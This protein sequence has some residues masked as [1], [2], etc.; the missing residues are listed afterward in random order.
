MAAALMFW[1]GLVG[2]LPAQIAQGLVGFLAIVTFTRMLSPE[3]YGAYALGF[4]AMSLAHTLAFTWLEAA[5]ARFYPAE[6]QEGGRL[7]D[8]FATIYRTFIVAAVLFPVV[9][10]LALWLWPVQAEVKLAVGA[11][12]AAVMVRSLAKLAQERRRAAG[13]VRSASLLDIAQTT[14]GFAAGAALIVVGFGGAAPMAGMGV[15]AAVSLAFVLPAELRF[16]KGGNFEPQRLRRYAA[17]GLP[18]AASLVLALA[19]ATT[20]RFLLAAYLNEQ[21]VG[22]Y[23]AGYSLSN[24]TLDVLFIW[25][26][27]A[28]G[29]AMVMALERGGEPALKASAR[30]QA[31]MMAALAFPAAVGLALVARPL[32]EVMIGP[33]LRDG[34]A[35]VT[36]WVAMSALFSGLTTYYFHQAFTLARRTPRLLAAMAIPALANI[37]LNVLLIPRFGLDGAM[38][39]TAASYGVGLISSWGLGRSVM[40]L[41]VPIEAVT[42]AAAATALMAFVVMQLPAIG[43]VA[44]LAL[45]SMAGAGVYGVCAILLDVGGLRTRASRLIAARRAGAAA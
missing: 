24:R 37:V 1:R 13:D 4:S 35:R 43:G 45:K 27:A 42:R 29:P 31:S 7:P 10:G 16:G 19:L 20:D 30:D 38:W 32:A 3:Q 23:H 26:G 39:A 6:A 8:H 21:T 36:P 40:A 25:L 28:G 41:P 14:G 34:A 33:G 17:Y 44:E 11:G 18:V 5:M 9:S 12:L 22:V 15:I 2:Y